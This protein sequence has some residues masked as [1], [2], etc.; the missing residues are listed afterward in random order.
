MGWMELGR[1]LSVVARISVNPCHTGNLPP[2]LAAL[3]SKPTSLFDDDDRL[4]SFFFFLLSVPSSTY[5][6]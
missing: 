2:G 5:M 1:R 4:V 3:P 6:D